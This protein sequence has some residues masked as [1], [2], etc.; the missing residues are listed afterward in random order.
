MSTIPTLG[1]KEDTTC[2]TNE[3]FN[4]GIFLVLLEGVEPT[5]F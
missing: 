3:S 4:L 2:I 1:H 5:T